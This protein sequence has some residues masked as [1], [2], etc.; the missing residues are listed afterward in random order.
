MRTWILQ[1]GQLHNNSAAEDW[2]RGKYQF[3]QN[4]PL[5]TTK[6]YITI[7]PVVTC[8]TWL[9]PTGG[10]TEEE[11]ARVDMILAE[12]ADLNSGFV[13]ICYNPEFVSLSLMFWPW[14]HFGCTSFQILSFLGIGIT[15]G[16]PIMLLYRALFQY[17]I[18]MTNNKK[19]VNF[20][21]YKKHDCNVCPVI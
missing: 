9:F 20:V 18:W 16:L 19:S 17:D 21:S 12:T 3:T 10:E 1:V 15:L 14:N 7:P 2:H 13:R 5:R 6:M 4:S 8:R 11:K